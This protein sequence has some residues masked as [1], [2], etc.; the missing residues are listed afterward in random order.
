MLT[1]YE[2][3]AGRHGDKLRI[4]FF[5]KIIPADGSPAYRER[6]VMEVD[7][8]PAQAVNFGRLILEQGFALRKALENEG[9]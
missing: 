1:D 3:K 4:G 2:F 6:V 8:T 7:M 5:R 9:K